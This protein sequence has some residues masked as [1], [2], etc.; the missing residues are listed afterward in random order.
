MTCPFL[1]EL[2]TVDVDAFSAVAPGVDF[3]TVQRPARMYVPA[4]A[5]QTEK[6]PVFVPAE[7]ANVLVRK[8]YKLAA[9]KRHVQHN[10]PVPA[11]KKRPLGHFQLVDQADSG[12]E[13]KRLRLTHP[14]RYS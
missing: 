13:S 1:A 8:F 4:E 14:S 10:P 7:A 11:V 3:E 2:P 12:D 9:A 5:A 6:P